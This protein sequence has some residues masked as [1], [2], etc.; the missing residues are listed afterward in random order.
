[1]LM[2]RALAKG[3]VLLSRHCFGTL[4]SHARARLEQRVSLLLG[5][6]NLILNLF[7]YEVVLLACLH[8]LDLVGVFVHRM[9]VRS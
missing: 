6:L 5:L 4:R 8:G 1:M 3:I 2:L 9:L 7:T